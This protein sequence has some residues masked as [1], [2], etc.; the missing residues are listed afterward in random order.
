MQMCWIIK[1]GI[2][3]ECA[4]TMRQ[5]ACLPS[6]KPL[7]IALGVRIS[8]LSHRITNMLDSVENTVKTLAGS[9]YS[10][11]R[12]R[13]SWKT[14]LLGKPWR[15]IRIPSNTPLHLSCSKTKWASSFPAWE[16]EICNFISFIYFFC[17][18]LCYGPLQC[19][20]SFFS[21]HLPF[22]RGWGWCI[23]QS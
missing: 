1:C 10:T 11:H 3:F 18:V 17:W 16:G 5:Q 12:W 8:Y 4:I 19:W 2:L 7:G 21:A 6:M 22:S 14:I 13:N 23:S 20:I 9:R 15:Q